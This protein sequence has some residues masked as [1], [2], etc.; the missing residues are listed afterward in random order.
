MCDPFSGSL[1]GTGKTWKLGK[2]RKLP[3]KLP[4]HQWPD[5]NLNGISGSERQ[6]VHNNATVGFS[7]DQLDLFALSSHVVYVHLFFSLPSLTVMR[8]IQSYNLSAWSVASLTTNFGPG[9]GWSN[10][11]MDPVPP[12]L[13]TWT[14]WNYVAYW[15]SDA[16]NVAMWQT[17]SSM[18]AIGLT[19]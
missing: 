8:G 9:A 16:T 10:K 18:L 12:H 7:M 3:G 11:D 4:Q 2:S 1:P 14:T 5:G 15:T 13:R 19:W 17:A 6:V